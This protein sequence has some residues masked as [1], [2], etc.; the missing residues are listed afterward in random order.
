M[1]YFSSISRIT[2]RVELDDKRHTR[3]RK[4]LTI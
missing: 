1:V 4:T 3:A 2:K